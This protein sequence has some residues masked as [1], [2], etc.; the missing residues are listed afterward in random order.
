VWGGWAEA[1]EEAKGSYDRRVDWRVRSYNRR[2]SRRVLEDIK[3]GDRGR[4]AVE[5]L[6]PRSWLVRRHVR[7][8]PSP[9]PWT[10]DCIRVKFL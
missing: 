10:R 4:V 9:T 2:V 8:S 1:R 6:A 3:R 7:K 5:S